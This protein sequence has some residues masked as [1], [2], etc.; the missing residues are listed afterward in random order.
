MVAALADTAFVSLFLVPGFLILGWKHVLDPNHHLGWS[1]TL[2]LWAWDIPPFAIRS[3]LIHFRGQTPG[4]WLAKI[5]IVRGDGSRLSWQRWLTHR[6]LPFELGSMLPVVGGFVPVVDFL[7]LL[8]G[9]KRFLHDILA[10][11]KV[12]KA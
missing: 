2:F 9:R 6:T 5:K 8:G 12:V 7:F 3:A 10:D 11:T 4:K 1:D